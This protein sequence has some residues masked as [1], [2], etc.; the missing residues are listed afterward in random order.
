[1][2]RVS[3]PAFSGST[4]RMALAAI[5][6]APL[7]LTFITRSPAHAGLTINATFDSSITNDPNAAAIEGTINQAIGFYENNITNSIAVNITFRE[8]TSGLGQSNWVAYKIRYQTYINALTANS[9]GDSSDT[10]ALAHLPTGANNP[11]NNST[12]INVKTANLRALG[13][14]VGFTG[15]DGTIGLNTH[16]TDVGSPGTTGQYSLFATTEH[17]ID[18]ILGLSSALDEIVRNRGP[19]WNDPLPED[20]FRYTGS[21]N[22]TRSFTTSGDNAYFSIDGTH[23]LVQFNSRGGSGDYGDWH[24]SSAP[25]V[26]DAFATPG[27]H[28]SL[29]LSSPEVVAL[30]AIGYNLQNPSAVPEPSS[31]TM[32]GIAMAGLLGYRLRR[33]RG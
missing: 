14:N 17:E 25:R 11:V 21:G 4:R 7:V 27:A 8:M 33:K 9:S 23:N 24:S 31:L 3:P 30:D 2:A 1:M 13:I 28:P 19:F 29:T 5:L 22:G 6:L 20:L 15:S 18:E 10:T 26:Q 12:T 32:L 16:I